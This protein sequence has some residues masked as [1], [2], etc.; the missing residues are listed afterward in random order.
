MT[1]ISA[2]AVSHSM[3]RPHFTLQWIQRHSKVP[4]GISQVR[5]KFCLFCNVHGLSLWSWPHS[6]YRELRNMHLQ[7]FTCCLPARTPCWSVTL[8]NG[9]L[10]Y[11]TWLPATAALAAQLWHRATSASVN[12]EKLVNIPENKTK[13]DFLKFYSSA[14]YF[15]MLD[16]SD[17]E[18]VRQQ[19]T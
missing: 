19:G 13:V 18:E 10:P 8:W 7:G 3:A 11:G 17:C 5:C 4:W 15:N 16:E 1:W 6:G 14:D 12:I 2:P 9:T